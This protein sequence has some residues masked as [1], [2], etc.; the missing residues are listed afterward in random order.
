ME[1]LG[2]LASIIQV[3]DGTVKV[4]E[5]ARSLK[6]KAQDQRRLAQECKNLLSILLQLRTEVQKAHENTDVTA[7]V[8]LNTI[9]DGLL[10]QIKMCT[11]DLANELD[12]LGHTSRILARYTWHFRKKD[13]AEILSNIERLKS[14]TGLALQQ[15]LMLVNRPIASHLHL[16]RS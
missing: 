6:A 4:V 10:E 7:A 9:K 16:E 2:V 12:F 15:M 3:I 11:D 14:L 8:R 1:A 5:Y 13:C